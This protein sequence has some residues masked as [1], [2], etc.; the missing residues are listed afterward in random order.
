MN[1]QPIIDLLKDAPFKRIAGIGALA[2]IGKEGGFL[3]AAYVIPATETATP[4]P[5]GSYILDQV[6]Q[7]T[8]AVV[9]AVHPDGVR[10]GAA[11]DEMDELEEAVLTRLFGKQP[12]G[13][14]SVLTLADI[15]TVDFSAGLIARVIRMRGRRRRRVTLQP[16]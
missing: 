7:S 6:I 14:D 5:E 9:I 11:G 1:V 8:V 16:A 4:A 3:P 12:E 2:K 13:W 15:H 10:K